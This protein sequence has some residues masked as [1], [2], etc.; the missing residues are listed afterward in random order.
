M[1]D[2]YLRFDH[3]NVG[4]VLDGREDATVRY[5]FDR[6]LEA[7]Q[8][9]ELHTPGGTVFAIAEI[10]DVWTCP[11]RLAYHDMVQVDG[12]A[13]PATDTH[14]LAVR[15]NTHYQGQVIDY[16]DEVTVVYF[17]VIEIGGGR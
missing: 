7:D 9:V 15:L 11:L 13:H 12:R 17:D 8:R 16:D 10:E 2:A 1:T 3:P 5:G 14:N 6:D 4:Y